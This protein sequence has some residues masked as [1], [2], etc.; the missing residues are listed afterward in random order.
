MA[1]EDLLFHGRFTPRGHKVLEYPTY[2]LGQ[3]GRYWNVLC[4]VMG[5]SGHMETRA[6][7]TRWISENIKNYVRLEA[8]LELEE[9]IRQ[10]RVKLA[11]HELPEVHHT[12]D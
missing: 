1:S 7:A 5:N 10:L 12:G 11:E 2:L 3:E 6:E 8:Y 4:S 9:E